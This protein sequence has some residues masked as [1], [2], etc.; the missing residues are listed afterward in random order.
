MAVGDTGGGKTLWVRM[1]GATDTYRM[2]KGELA[3]RRTGS[4]GQVCLFV[5]GGQGE[6]SGG[7]CA[8][9]VPGPGSGT[10]RQ[11]F[12]CPV[13]GRYSARGMQDT[14]LCDMSPAQQDLAWKSGRMEAQHWRGQSD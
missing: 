14:G 3:L 11:T 10:V 2:W 4:L 7:C 5:H 8:Q 9:V 1:H 12:P 13:S 6:Q